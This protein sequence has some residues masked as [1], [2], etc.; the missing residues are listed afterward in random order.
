MIC[1]STQTR[2]DHLPP[3]P[4]PGLRAGRA[5]GGEQPARQGPRARIYIYIYTYVYIYI[6]IHV[7]I[8]IRYIYIYIYTH[9]YNT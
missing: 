1:T 5:R 6:Y 3:H 7:Y 8:C 4:P 2:S 9:T